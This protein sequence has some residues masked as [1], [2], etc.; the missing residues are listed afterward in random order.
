MMQPD[1]TGPLSRGILGGTLL[2]RPDRAVDGD[3]WPVNGAS[4]VQVSMKIR[5]SAAISC[6]AVML[7]GNAVAE[8]ASRPP[9]F[10]YNSDA[11]HMYYY[12]TPPMTVEQLQ[13]YVD[14]V[15]GTGVTTFFASPNWGMMMSHPSD[16]SEMIGE[17]L[18]A[19]E[20]QEYRR[21]GIEKEISAERAISNVHAILESGHDPFGVMIDRAREQ[22]LEIFVSFR[23]NEIHDVQNPDSMIVSKFWRDHPEWRVGT[24]GDEITPLFR[25]IIGGRPEHRVH[26]I[27]ASWFPG[28]L[29]FAVPQVRERRLAQLRECCERYDLDGLD[30]DFQRFPIYFPQDEGAEHTATMTAWMRQVRELTNEIGAQRGRPILLCARILAKPEQNLA[31]GLDPFTWAEEGLVDFV[32]VS[33]YLRNDFPL[34]IEEFR[35]R[36]PAD[37]PIYASVEVEREAESF[38]RIAKELYESGADGLMMFNYFTWREGSKEPDFSL[39]KEL[40]DPQELGVVRP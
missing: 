34:P 20:K 14:E 35:Q 15:V 2:R 8:D 12:K 27:V 17:G 5:I 40:S 16:V 36:M 9:R 7:A 6:A 37:L 29:N 18:T 32:T 19:E 13:G 28:A 10:I 21:I 22:G 1:E 38:R 23:L 31:I 4:Q 30:L 25:E 33:H 24:H 26:P 3:E 11:N 39:F